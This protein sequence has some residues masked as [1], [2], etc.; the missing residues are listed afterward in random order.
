MPVPCCCCNAPN[1]SVR[2]S[3]PTKTPKNKIP[4]ITPKIII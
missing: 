3:L 2:K 1:N 4:N